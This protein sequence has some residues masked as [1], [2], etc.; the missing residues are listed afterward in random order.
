VLFQNGTQ[1]ASFEAGNEGQGFIAGIGDISVS[2]RFD[3]EYTRWAFTHRELL[4]TGDSGN[5][6][7]NGVHA[8]RAGT[9]DQKRSIIVSC[10]GNIDRLVVVIKAA[11]GAHPLVVSLDAVI[12]DDKDALGRCAN[13]ED[14]R[15]GRQY[16]ERVHWLVEAD[17]ADNLV[18]VVV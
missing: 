5:V 8:V 16:C 2:A 1:A 13:H 12:A 18:G 3:R 17:A 7:I 14:L 10:D 6:F 15:R 11:D 4:F 9:D